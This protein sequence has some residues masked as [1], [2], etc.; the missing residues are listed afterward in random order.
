MMQ[1]A[2]ELIQLRTSWRSCTGDPIPTK[3]LAL[4]DEYIMTKTQGVFAGKVRFEI[5]AARSGDPDELKGLGTYGFIQGASG[6]IVGAIDKDIN[7]LEDYGYLMEEI[8]LYATLLG[9]AT[10]WLGGSFQK[11]NFS[12]RINIQAHEIVP[13][14]VSI[15]IGAGSRNLMDRLIRNVAGSKK[16]LP[17]EQLFFEAD[18]KTPLRRQ[19]VG[20]LTHV[21]EM[22]RL[23]PSASNKQP[24]RLVLDG[25]SVHF[26]LK[27]SKGYRKS[28]FSD[29]Q[30]IDMGIAMCHFEA[31][32]KELNISATWKIQNPLDD[33]CEHWEYLSTWVGHEQ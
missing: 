18:C 21:F 27:R 26:F 10:C 33:T 3:T 2:T 15:G 4:L 12:A 30:R 8:I 13:A 25:N 5:V 16:R 17:W 29:L 19:D 24:W 28:M 20:K 31:A 7:N 14:V 11:D 1:T 22:V 32:C 6:F 9:L 23:S